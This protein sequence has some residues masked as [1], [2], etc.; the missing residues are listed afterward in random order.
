MQISLVPQKIYFSFSVLG[1]PQ[2]PT[3]FSPFQQEPFSIISIN[4]LLTQEI[5]V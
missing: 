4:I 3:V 1:L 5:V 2:T